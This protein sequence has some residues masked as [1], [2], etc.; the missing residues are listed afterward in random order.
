MKRHPYRISALVLSLILIS[1]LAFVCSSSDVHK[2]KVKVDQGATL[3]NAAAKTNRD[4]YQSG[5]YG[6]VGS[7]VAIAKRQ[8]AAKAIHEANG[9]LSEAVEVAATL[10]AGDTGSAVIDLLQQALT[11]LASA[12]IGNPQMDL[13]IQAAVAIINDAV[14]LARS[15]KGGL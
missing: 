15:L 4:L 9:L 7:A 14:M 1:Q 3:L 5:V 13:A 8:K 6:A 2:I 11:A 12:H 10:K